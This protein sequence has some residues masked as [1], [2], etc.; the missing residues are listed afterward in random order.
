MVNLKHPK[1]DPDLTLT[2]ILLSILLVDV[3][4]LFFRD[5]WLDNDVIYQLIKVNVE[6]KI[7]K[8]LENFTVNLSTS[9][10][11]DSICD[12][13]QGT[14]K[15]QIDLI[16]RLESANIF[17]TFLKIRIPLIY[18]SKFFPISGALKF[19]GLSRDQILEKLMVLTSHQE[20]NQEFLLNAV[21][22]LISHLLTTSN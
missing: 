11:I 1:I 22:L 16:S 12:W 4:N 17:G 6:E 10:V 8:C 19:F 21:Q 15:N 7:E 2:S 9:K 13:I 14:S 18:L 5:N 20:R 3:P